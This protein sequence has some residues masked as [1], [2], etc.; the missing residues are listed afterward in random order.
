MH[1]NEEISVEL[2]HAGTPIGFIWRGITYRVVT[3]TETW[4]TRR[5][6]WNE[7]ASVARDALH[8]SLDV[9]VWRVDATPSS[10]IGAGMNGTFDL[11]CYDTPHEATPD[12][13]FTRRVG[14]LL[15]SAWTDVLDDRLLA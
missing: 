15:M 10:T 5:A 3:T 9:P 11:A 6:W 12:E 1:I 8:G 14:W 13:N 4:L 7:P 2:G